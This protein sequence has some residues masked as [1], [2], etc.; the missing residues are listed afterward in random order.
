MSEPSTNGAKDAERS[1]SDFCLPDRNL[2]KSVAIVAMGQS[3]RSYVVEAMQ[4]GDRF[5]LVDEVWAINNAGGV[6]KH[7]RLFHMDDLHIQRSRAEDDPESPIG[8][9]MDW[10]P[11]HDRPVYTPRQYEWAPSS[12]EYPLEWVLNRT[13]HCYFNNTVPYA[14]AFAI[15]LGVPKIHLY[16]CDYGYSDDQAF[17]R[18]RG[19]ACLEYWIGVASEKHIGIRL[20][21]DSTLLDAVENRSGQ[22]FYGY[23][24]EDVTV[25]LDPRPKAEGGGFTIT[26]EPL[27][28]AE[29]PTAKQMNIRYSHDTRF[30]H[31]EAKV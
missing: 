4:A 28:E 19:R 9:V 1:P 6:V 31:L 10:L 24:T 20:P 12:V 3:V 11:T 29:I 22:K 30:E 2:P 27:P 8:G 25:E 5:R 13:G 23:D 7:D 21:G 14:L 18:E 26:R 16:G 17:K 15:A